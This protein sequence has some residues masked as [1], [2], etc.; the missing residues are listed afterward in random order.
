MSDLLPELVIGGGPFARGAQHGESRR[1][2]IRAFLDDGLA[3]VDSVRKTPLGRAEAR[4]LAA[5]HAAVIE[6]DVPELADELRGLAA[7]ADIDYLDAVILQIRRELI[8]RGSDCTTLAGPTGDGGYVIAQNVDLPG[9]LTDLGMLLRVCAHAATPEI[10]M[11]THVGLLG[12]LG[13]NGDGLAVGI[14]MVLADGWRPGVPPYL[15]VRRIL[16]QRT[17]DAALAELQRIRRASSRSLVLAQ[18]ERLINVELTVDRMAILEPPLIIHTNHYLH[19]ELQAS[20]RVSRESSTFE[21]WERTRALVGERR[22]LD[23]ALLR[24]V[25]TDHVGARGA[26]CCHGN[27]DAA[28]AQTIVS[29]MLWAAE[30]RMSAARGTPCTAAFGDTWIAAPD[31]FSRNNRPLAA[32]TRG[33]SP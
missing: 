21:R 16:E 18:G 25:L 14:N 28:R 12:Y 17:L 9:N 5:R 32:S 4:V 29:V 20:D 30:R 3:R 27:G 7:G 23:A 2:T 26:I 24:S 13:L 1:A 8:G 31:T 19:P 15:L 10:L 22:T 11:F 6:A 33:Q